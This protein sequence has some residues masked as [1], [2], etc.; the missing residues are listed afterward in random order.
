M[1]Q[2]DKRE[3]AIQEIAEMLRRNTFQM[4]VQVKKKPQGIR[5][6]YEVTQEELDAAIENQNRRNKHGC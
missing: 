6:I 1:T 5:I 4:E 3:K 2:E